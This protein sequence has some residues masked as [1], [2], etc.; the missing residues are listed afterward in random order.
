MGKKETQIVEKHGIKIVHI[1]DHDFVQGWL[2][3]L[4]KSGVFVSA[5]DL[6]Q[7]YTEESENGIGNSR[8]AKSDIE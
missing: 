3:D 6:A 5:E 8:N 1:D 7:L 2:H 4:T